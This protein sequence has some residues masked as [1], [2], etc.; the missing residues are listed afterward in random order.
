M[1]ILS[2]AIS[3]E[4]ATV[5][6]STTGVATPVR[7]IGWSR[8]ADRASWHFIFDKSICVTK[9]WSFFPIFSFWPEQ[10]TWLYCSPGPCWHFRYLFGCQSSD[11]VDAPGD[12]VWREVK[13]RQNRGLS[14][15]STWNLC[16]QSRRM[17]LCSSARQHRHR[18]REPHHRLHGLSEGPVHA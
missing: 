13:V 17:P 15:V 2:S 10:S 6:Q 1:Q 11:G 3:P 7:F 9:C 8:D 18:R 12:L 5:T 4:R 14:G 16:S